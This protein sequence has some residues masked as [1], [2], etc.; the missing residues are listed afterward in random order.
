MASS[1]PEELLHSI[2]S[3]LQPKLAEPYEGPCSKANRL[4]CSTLVN[5]CRVNKTCYRLASP[6]LYETIEIYGPKNYRRS[7]PALSGYPSN[8]LP[9]VRTLCGNAVLAKQVKQI[10]IEQ[11]EHTPPDASQ[12]LLDQFH[13]FFR[14]PKSDRSKVRPRKSNTRDGPAKVD[15]ETRAIIER[16]IE[17]FGLSPDLRDDLQDGLY[18]GLED[19][20]LAVVL[21]LCTQIVHLEFMAIFGLSDTL[22]M[23]V[24]DE[25]ATKY[26]AP[27]LSEGRP[28]E[29]LHSLAVRNEIAPRLDFGFCLDEITPLLKAPNLRTL[30]GYCLQCVSC[31]G[32]PPP[33]NVSPTLTRFQI[34]RG[35]LDDAGVELAFQ[36]FPGLREISYTEGDMIEWNFN[37]ESFGDQLRNHGANLERLILDQVEVGQ[38][39]LGDLSSLQKLTHFSVDVSILLGGNDDE[40]DTQW[41]DIAQMVDKLPVSLNFLALF[42]GDRNMRDYWWIVDRQISHLMGSN[43]F[44]AL[45]TIELRRPAPFAESDLAPGWEMTAADETMTRLQR[46]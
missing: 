31:T 26:E 21:P 42:F 13:D 3:H 1:L 19:A 2:F 29:K 7:R 32:N 45:S 4:L 44:Q 6:L 23:A 8:L 33:A 9:L 12:Q 40:T 41:D 46:Y 27:I 17:P 18:H 43:V 35:V 39:C 15:D 30:R 24:V 20:M 5:V 25:L 36:F 11:F 22:T 34:D 16:A 14:K 37:A 28:F 38:E 10:K